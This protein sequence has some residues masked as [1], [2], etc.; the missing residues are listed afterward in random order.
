M[1][2]KLITNG[3]H[4]EII[5]FLFFLLCYGYFLVRSSIVLTEIKYF[6]TG[7]KFDFYDCFKLR[8]WFTIPIVKTIWSISLSKRPACPATPT[9]KYNL[10]LR[11]FSNTSSSQNVKINQ[12][13]WWQPVL[14]ISY[15]TKL[16]TN[17]CTGPLK[18]IEDYNNQKW[19][20]CPSNLI[21]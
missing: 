9:S 18:I 21:D 4:I 16:S 2:E 20:F 1:S 15:K 8:Y 13:I 3:T 10:K 14:L 19:M 17:F 7:H 6:R 12:Y 11:N 5:V